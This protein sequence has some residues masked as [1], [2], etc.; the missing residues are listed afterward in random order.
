MLERHRFEVV[1]ALSADGALTTLEASAEAIDLVISDMVMPGLSGLELRQ[2]IR[3]IRPGLP[4]LLMSGYSEEAITRLGSAAAVGPL[5]EK[6][7]TVDGML[8]KVRE[9][10]S[11]ERAG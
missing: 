2:R 5:I 11:G 9:T 3:A 4:V 7:F 8:Q 6:P 1:E 10:L